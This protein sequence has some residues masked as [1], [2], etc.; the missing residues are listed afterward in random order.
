MRVGAW[1]VHEPWAYRGMLA[2]YSHASPPLTSIKP[3]FGHLLGASSLLN[4][5]AT[6][7]MIK[8]QVIAPTAN[9]AEPDPE[10]PQDHVTGGPR[11]TS[12]ENALSFAFAIGSLSSVTLMRRV[13][14]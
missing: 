6:A 8:N 9:C 1:L 12:I 14:V 3:V 13:G 5:M 2:P 7:L 4:C 11:E 10:C